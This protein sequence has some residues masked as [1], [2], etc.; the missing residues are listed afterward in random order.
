MPYARYMKSSS[1]YLTN[2]R[3]P[4][5]EERFQVPTVFVSFYRSCTSSLPLNGKNV[6]YNLNIVYKMGVCVTPRRFAHLPH[7]FLPSHTL[8]TIVEDEGVQLQSADSNAAGQYITSILGS[9]QKE[10]SKG[11]SCR[12]Q[13]YTRSPLFCSR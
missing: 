11:F 2:H 9:D 8:F 7:I 5:A 4:T 12:W 6:C 10:I 3:L 13:A 1:S